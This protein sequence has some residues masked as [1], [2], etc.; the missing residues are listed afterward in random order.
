MKFPYGI[1]DF[2]KVARHG[3]RLR[4][5]TYAVV[6]LGFDRLVGVEV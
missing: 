2:V 1:S 5:R 3:E 6:S 4:L